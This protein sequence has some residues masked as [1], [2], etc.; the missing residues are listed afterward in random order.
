MSPRLEWL[1]LLLFPLVASGLR[2]RPLGRLLAAP[3]RTAKSLLKE[4]QAKYPGKF[5]DSVLRTLQRRVSEW[6]AQAMIEAEV[7]AAGD[8]P[9]G[10][11]ESVGRYS[12]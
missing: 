8:R 4:L 9:G 3:D 6:R 7:T 11:R 10:T 5:P 2:L 12:D 1:L